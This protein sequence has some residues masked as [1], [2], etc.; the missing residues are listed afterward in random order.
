MKRFPLFVTALLLFSTGAKADLVTTSF[1]NTFF[2]SPGIV[3]DDEM[4]Y[5]TFS[6]N[7]NTGEVIGDNLNNTIQSSGWC[8]LKS[9][10]SFYFFAYNTGKINPTIQEVMS[11]SPGDGLVYDVNSI[12][13]QR[14][15]NGSSISDTNHSEVPV[16][17]GKIVEIPDN[18]YYVGFQSRYSYHIYNGYAKIRNGKYKP[19]T[20]TLDKRVKSIFKFA[21]LL[22]HTYACIRFVK[23]WFIEWVF[24]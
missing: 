2:G 18:E 20:T 10:G 22:F 8:F 19:N 9:G 11:A 16:Q 7:A 14:Y 12:F 23:H 1:V 6:F 5:Y 13:L 21:L 3:V 24:L 4:P 15:S 17:Y